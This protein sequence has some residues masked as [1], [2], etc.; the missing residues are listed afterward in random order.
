MGAAAEAARLQG[1]LDG[2][3][4]LASEV[5]ALVE[6]RPDP[7]A[8]ERA[9]SALGSVAHFRGDF[10]GARTAWLRG[11][12]LGAPTAGSL[13]ASAALAAAYGGEVQDARVLLDR[14]H[15]VIAAAPCDSHVAFAAYVEGEL[16]AND[17]VEDSVPYYREAMAVARR[18]GATFVEGV[19]SVALAS[20]NTR[21][22]DVA[23][24]AEG[25]DCL[26]DA[27]SR[28]G[29]TTQLWTTARNAAGLL[30]SV[31]ATH[32]AALVLVCADRQPGAAA[33][34]PAIARYSGRMYVPLADLVAGHEVQ[35]L[36]AEVDRLTPAGVL[37]L[38]RRELGALQ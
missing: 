12:E 38:L 30:A 19:A 10:S 33:V 20:A 5:L 11:S 34:D 35:G 14:A 32:T 13:V 29:Q 3:E 2:A 24:A 26:L 27:W 9:W 7:I 21:T 25:F 22:G 8:E 36:S 4:R 37:D 17:R 23:A 31:G 6:L 15:A 28:T 18:C 16:R 1:D